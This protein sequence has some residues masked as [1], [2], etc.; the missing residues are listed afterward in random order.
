MSLRFL[1]L[2]LEESSIILTDT[3]VLSVTIRLWIPTLKVKAGR[4]WLIYSCWFWWANQVPCVQTSQRFKKTKINKNQTLCWVSGLALWPL[5][6][7]LLLPDT[8]FLRHF[9]PVIWNGTF[10]YTNIIPPDWRKERESQLSVHYAQWKPDWSQTLQRNTNP[11]SK[12][13]QIEPARR[14]CIQTS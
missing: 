3:G 12:L 6:P 14:N 4:N 9:K 7:W 10:K 13:S 5:L 8:I 2:V 11:N 1:E